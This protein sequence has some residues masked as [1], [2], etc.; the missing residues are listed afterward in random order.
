MQETWVLSLDQEDPPEEEIT[1]HSSIFAWEIP[2]AEESGGLYSPW[3]HKR[4]RHDLSMSQQQVEV[5]SRNFP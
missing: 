4:V 1:V 5:T 2:Q 3:G